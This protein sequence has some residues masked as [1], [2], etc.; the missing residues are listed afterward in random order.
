MIS[1]AFKLG[2]RLADSCFASEATQLF[3]EVPEP[4]QSKAATSLLSVP[5]LVCL[6][7][8]PFIN[9]ELS[10]I[11][12]M[13]ILVLRFGSRILRTNLRASVGNQ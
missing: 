10:L 12:S 8:D 11:S 9:H 6:E 4:F 2:G 7:F 3:S 5:V 13:E 1:K